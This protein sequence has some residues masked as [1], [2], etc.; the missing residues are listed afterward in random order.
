MDTVSFVGDRLTWQQG[1]QLGL[2]AA[3]DAPSVCCSKSSHDMKSE[4]KPFNVALVCQS[5]TFFPFS[6]FDE[7]LDSPIS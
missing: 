4:G 5:I 2:S 7:K 3:P 1:N 6:I